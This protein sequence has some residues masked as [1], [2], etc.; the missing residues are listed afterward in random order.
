MNLE[1]TRI[2][3]TEKESEEVDK[4]DK[5]CVFLNKFPKELKDNYEESFVYK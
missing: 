4:N 5:L 3:F 1:L 2:I